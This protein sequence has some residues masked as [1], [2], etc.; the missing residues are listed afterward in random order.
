MPAPL[1]LG[2][3]E[4]VRSLLSGGLTLSQV[5]RRTGLSRTTVFKILT[6]RWRPALTAADIH[7]DR[8]PGFEQRNLAR[9]PGCRALVYLWPCMRCDLQAR[10]DERH[11]IRRLCRRRAACAP[12][13]RPNCQKP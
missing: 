4:R 9:C 11:E 12:S 6:R 8:P 7:D 5:A 2:Q 3:A 13:D 10:A 1:L